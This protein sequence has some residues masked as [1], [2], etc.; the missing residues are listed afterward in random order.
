MLSHHHLKKLVDILHFHLKYLLNLIA[1]FYCI[2]IPGLLFRVFKIPY[3]IRNCFFL[4][5]F[6]FLDKC[7]S[8]HHYFFR[9]SFLNFGL[10]STKVIIEKHKSSI[11]KLIMHLKRA[12]NSISNIHESMFVFRLFGKI[13]SLNENGMRDAYGCLIQS[14]D[15]LWV[16]NKRDVVLLKLLIKLCFFIYIFHIQLYC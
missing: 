15:L 7:Y 2:F 13:Q 11:F 5:C 6:F 3:D 8:I 9:N 4:F 10:V 1:M 14:C 16:W 12:W